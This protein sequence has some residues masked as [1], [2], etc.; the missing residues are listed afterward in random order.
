MGSRINSFFKDYLIDL[1]NFPLLSHKYVAK[2]NAKDICISFF[3]DC[4][5][6]LVI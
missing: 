2:Y 5:Y 1:K 4:P 6:P 3:G